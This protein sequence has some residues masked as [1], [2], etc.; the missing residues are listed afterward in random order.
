MSVRA[1]ELPYGWVETTLGEVCTDPQYGYTTK[2][3]SEGDLH[4]LRTTDIT[5]GRIDWGTVPYCSEPPP[6]ESKYLVQE[7]DI[8]ISRAGSIGVSHLIRQPQRS[9]FASYL[10]RFKPLIN[11][12]F[13]K[14]YLHS[15]SYWN[16][17]SEKR[18]GIAIP[19]VNASKLKTIPFPLAP[20]GEQQRIVAKIE[21][22]L[23]ELDNGI[24]N[25]IAAKEQ[26]RVYRQALLKHAFE[27]KLSA[28]WRAVNKDKL[29]ACLKIDAS[30]GAFPL[31]ETW[32]WLRVRDILLEGP[33]NG[34]SVKDRHDGFP[35]LRLT[36]LKG[37][38]IDLTEHKQGDWDREAALPF[39]VKEGDFLLSRGNGSKHLVGRGGLVP[40]YAG[41]VAYPDTII[42]LKVDPRFI[43]N[44]FFCLLWNSQ[45]VRRQIESAARTTAGIYKIN[46]NDLKSFAIP[47]PSL[48]E[49]AEIVASLDEKLSVTDSLESEVE[50]QLQAA[51]SLRQSILQR[52]FTGQLVA[53]DPSDE[54]AS[55]LL[56]KI[57]AERE[58]NN[59]K[60]KRKDAA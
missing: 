59:K 56:E 14:H 26:L 5:S 22:L 48:G 23:S 18:L 28:T 2:A 35:V 42:R 8:V 33:S 47:V 13:F 17:I 21:E 41:E 6:D 20:I 1:T 58:P 29:K 12:D 16:A 52:A 30:I 24:T 32:N 46:Q 44:E 7:G 11:P 39:I 57:K 54:P 55:A 19:N 51:H 40:E 27:G 4:L 31:P 49:Q 38:R 15:Q 60:I 9:V 10:I 53:Q 37:G 43:R 36:A 45:I 25:L 50:V 34:R 3:A